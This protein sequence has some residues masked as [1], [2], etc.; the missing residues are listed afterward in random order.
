MRFRYGESIEKAQEYGLHATDPDD[1]VL[2]YGTLK[3]NNNDEHSKPS[4]KSDGDAASDRTLES[5]VNQTSD[6]IRYVAPSRSSSKAPGT[7]SEE[8]DHYKPGREV[9]LQISASTLN[10]DLYLKRQFYHETWKPRIRT[11]MARDLEKKT[12]IPHLGN[13]ELYKGEVVGSLRKKR[14]ENP[15]PPVSRLGLLWEKSRATAKETIEES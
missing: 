7:G 14:D 4:S 1:L 11:I 2:S 10:H 12:P 13:F 5:E 3:S 6:K 8:N 15:T 9:H